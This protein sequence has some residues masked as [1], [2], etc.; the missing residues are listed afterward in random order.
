M[1]LNISVKMVAALCSSI[2][3]VQPA[4]ASENIRVYA[5]A[6]L[7]NA[8]NEIKSN[9]EK[10]PDVV[11]Q[12]VSIKTAYAG[13]ST[14]AKQIEAGAP[15]QILAS[16]D[17]QWMD[18][19]QKRHLIDNTSRRDLL[20]N[21]LVMIAPKNQ[22]VSVQLKAGV[23]DPDVLKGR[24]CTG[25]PASVPVGK[26]AKQALQNLGW[27]TALEKKIVATDDVR[28]ALAFVERGECPIGIVYATDAKV[29]DKVV[30]VARF[31]APL[32]TA[33]VYP[34]ALTPKATPAAKAFYQY[35]QS[36]A[37]KTVFRNYGFSINDKPKALGNKT[38]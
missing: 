19:V 23:V 7:T 3:V 4:W 8:L 33:I 26:Y 18:Y 14:L 17:Q 38:Q 35:L 34:F 27:W 5:A 31:P 9:Y 11:A 12:D 32:H 2:M 37:A 15:A 10:R 25:D 6:S 36:D 30:V 13:S 20:G 22:I 29:T 16:A 1:R 21:Q 28:T 24:I